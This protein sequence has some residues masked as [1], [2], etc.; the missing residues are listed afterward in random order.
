MLNQH[1][2]TL[3]NEVFSAIYAKDQA[4]DDNTF[5]RLVNDLDDDDNQHVDIIR[6][7]DKC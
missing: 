4:P 3:D 1:C 7:E 5:D 6:V 2:S